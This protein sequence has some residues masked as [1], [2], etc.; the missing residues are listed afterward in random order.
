M[1]DRSEQTRTGDISLPFLGKAAN[2][3]SMI[4]KIVLILAVSVGGATGWKLGAPGGIMGSYL[5]AVFGASVGLYIGRRLQ[6]NL[7]GAD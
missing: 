3:F 4:G 6:K 7:D 2:Y 5:A 1:P